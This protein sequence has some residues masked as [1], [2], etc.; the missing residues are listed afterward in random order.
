MNKIIIFLFAFIFSL[1]AFSANRYVRAA[2]GNSSAASTWASTSGGTDS[3]AVPTS[4]DD[5]F[6]D[7]ASGQLTI[8]AT[9]NCKSFNCT[10][11]T[12]TLTH[13][14]VALA[15]QGNVTFVAGMTYTTTSGTIQFDQ[16][17]T[18]I[19]AGKLIASLNCSNS[20]GSVVLGD[21][22]SYV[23]SKT[24]LLA[25]RGAGLDLN[26]KTV[27]GNSAT[28]RVLVR[29]N[30]TV[31][32]GTSQPIIVNGGTF[33]NCD[34]RDI[35]FSS[36]SNLD[37]SAIT[38]GSGD[39]G[40]NSITGGGTVL[41]FTTPVDQHWTSGV[42]GNWSNAA[43]WTSRVPLPQDNVFFDVGFSASQTVTA[44]MPRLGKTIDWTGATGTPTFAMT[45]VANTAY[46]GLT[47]ISGMIIS[48]SQNQTFEGRGSFNITSAGKN[49][50]SST[51]I[52]IAA[53]GGT[54][55]LLDSLSMNDSLY[56]LNGTLNLN[57]FN[58]TSYFFVSA[59]ISNVRCLNMGSGTYTAVGTSGDIWNVDTS[60]NMTFTK[61]TSKI[62]IS[63]LG[64]STKGWKGSG[65]DYYDV[66]FTG[67]GT[68][69]IL[70]KNSSSFRNITINPPKTVNF[71]AGTTQTVAS[72]TAV[73]TQA[74]PITI[75]STS[76]GSAA[77]L[78]DESGSNILK[79]CSIKDITVQGGAKWVSPLALG[80]TDVS[81]NTGWTWYLA[82][83]LF[84]IND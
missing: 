54:Y 79:Y 16:A 70:F 1:N 73:G 49:F 44:D 67:G 74:N 65:L 80:N 32:L 10:G 5:V 24:C 43:R 20:I 62:I 47:L 35:Q 63:G 61:G 14:S 17:A 23:A 77:T 84:W 8:D 82:L 3:V 30:S 50:G 75:Q 13:N 45:S 4:A 12:G 38:G 48:S 27:T 37:L 9:F 76:A 31:A 51:R 34:F 53:F 56:L 39:C 2:G 29:P 36:V 18:F 81:G 7:A 66:E 25:T 46:G 57:N 19:S 28:N 11:Y 26:G 68:G 69:A 83:G 42:T 78:S 59:G 71:E 64:A 6:L 72:F 41:T 40:G 21:N 55:T 33:A 60:T 15:S 22:I 52:S 58:V